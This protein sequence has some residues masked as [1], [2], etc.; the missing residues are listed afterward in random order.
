MAIFNSYAKLPEG[1]Q[2]SKNRT[3]LPSEM[4]R[5]K[6]GISPRI[7][8]SQSYSQS[9]RC[10][11]FGSLWTEN[12]GGCSTQTTIYFIVI[13][14]RKTENIWI[15]KY[16]WNQASVTWWNSAL[17]VGSKA[18]YSTSWCAKDPLV[19]LANLEIRHEATVRYSLIPQSDVR[20]RWHGWIELLPI[21]GKSPSYVIFQ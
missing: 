18:L 13:G 11:S 19:V 2:R 1:T 7:F 8:R 5:H 12:M 15:W 3:C 17:D 9:H 10:N 4:L 21:M 14:Y 20:A 16:D 6:V